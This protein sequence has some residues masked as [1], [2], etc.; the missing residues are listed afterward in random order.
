MASYCLQFG[1]ANKRA[2]ANNQALRHSRPANDLRPQVAAIVGRPGESTGEREET[3]FRRR[4]LTNQQA[5][6]LASCDKSEQV[7]PPVLSVGPSN[8]RALYWPRATCCCCCCCCCLESTKSGSR[9]ANRWFVA[10]GGGDDE[11]EIDSGAGLLAASGP[12]TSG[13]LR[14]GL[15]EWDRRPPGATKPRRSHAMDRAD[16]ANFGWTSSKQTNRRRSNWGDTM[17]NWRLLSGAP[18]PRRH[19]RLSRR[20]SR[21]RIV[22]SDSQ[23]WRSIS[24]D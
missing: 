8:L 6:W 10:A 19:C 5:A 11:D 24:A 14:D 17:T 21:G 1:S 12:S 23:D 13:G 2:I 22:K 16:E 20:P 4:W 3:L 7:S 18:P 9:R 15:E